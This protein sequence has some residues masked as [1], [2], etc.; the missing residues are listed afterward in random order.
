MGN[1]N[2]ERV[3]GEIRGVPTC[4][5]RQIDSL[6]TID[7][8]NFDRRKPCGAS[9]AAH[10]DREVLPRIRFISQDE[11]LDSNGDDR[12]PFHIKGEGE[13]PFDLTRSRGDHASTVD[14]LAR[15]GETPISC[16]CGI[17]LVTKDEHLGPRRNMDRIGRKN[18]IEGRDEI[19]PD[20]DEEKGDQQP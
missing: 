5:P 10:F 17:A 16:P 6:Q 8:P 13:Q 12:V 14:S 9:V 19:R 20:S 3:S 11:D 2:L 1:A 18:G 15:G 4:D 7:R